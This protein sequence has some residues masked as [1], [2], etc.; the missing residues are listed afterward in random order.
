[1]PDMMFK[2][3]VKSRIENTSRIRAMTFKVR[4]S[5]LNSSLGAGYDY[6]H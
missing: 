4:R 6:G 1:M 3:M 5:L 2:V